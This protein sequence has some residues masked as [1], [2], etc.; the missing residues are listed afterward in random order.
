MDKRELPENLRKIK[1]YESSNH[2]RNFLDCVKSRELTIAPVEVAHHSTIPGHL[3]LISM[4][5]RR[6]IRWNAEKEVIIG[7]SQAS[8][9]LRRPFREPWKLRV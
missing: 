4:L 9:L 5:V 2:Y 3:G 6:K 7:D 1:L 8:K